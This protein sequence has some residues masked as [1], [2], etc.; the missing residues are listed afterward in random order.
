MT[1]SIA[2]TTFNGERYLEEQL[3]SIAAQTRPPDELVVHDDGST[4]KS[5]QL[6]HDF[7]HSAPFPVHIVANPTT[8]GYTANFEAA[9][10]HCIGDLIFLADQDDCW[11]PE[12]IAV[13]ESVFLS[14][15]DLMLAIHDGELADHNLHTT[16]IGKLEQIRAGYRDDTGFA[17]GALTA[18]RRPLLKYAL[19]IPQG[20]TGHDSWLHYVAGMLE[21]RKVIDASLQ[22]IRRH[23]AN[24]SQWIVNSLQPISRGDVLRQLHAQTPASTYANRL[25]YNK[26]LL[27]RL[28]DSV[29]QDVTDRLTAE[30]AAIVRREDLLNKNWLLRKLKAGQ[31][32]IRGDY[33]YFNGVSSFVRDILR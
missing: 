1:V 23:D 19:P 2:M 11:F 24:S 7:Q 3:R 15:P 32:L 25:I 20:V 21:S 30:G 12:K 17:T 4:D 8:L 5:L 10:R 29:P 27:S 33:R 26:T 16:G 18:L 31:M 28:D 9:L 22:L 6:L 13:M 14:E